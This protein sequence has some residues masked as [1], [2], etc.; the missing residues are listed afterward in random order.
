MSSIISHLVRPL[1]GLPHFLLPPPLCRTLVPDVDVPVLLQVEAAEAL[2]RLAL[3]PGAE[4][5]GVHAAVAVDGAQVV[6]EAVA[7]LPVQLDALGAAVVA[8]GL[9]AGVAPGAELAR[10]LDGV[11][12]EHRIG[13]AVA[14]GVGGGGHQGEAGWRRRGWRVSRQRHGQRREKRQKRRRQLEEAHLGQDVAQLGRE[15]E[16]VRP[17]DFPNSIFLFL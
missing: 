9:A 7:P 1:A 5:A 17:S 2:V 8:R 15:L 11:V 16:R 13:V 14:V 10:A 6:A 4:G 3:L 12:V